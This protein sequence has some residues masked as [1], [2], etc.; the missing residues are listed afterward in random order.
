MGRAPLRGTL[1]DLPP[2]AIAGLAVVTIAV[3]WFL[4]LFGLSLLAFLAADIIVATVKRSSR[5]EKSG[6]SSRLR[7]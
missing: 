2:L 4:P 3:G 5:L 1:R 6:T 7:E